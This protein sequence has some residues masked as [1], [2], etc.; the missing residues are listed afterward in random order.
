MAK[1]KIA[2][3]FTDWGMNDYRKNNNLYGGIG[4]YRIVKPAEA[5][6]EWYDIDVIGANFRFWGN[7]EQAFTRLCKDY[8]LIYSKHID[9]GKAGSNILALANHFNKK[10]IVD[11][12]DNYLAIREDNPAYKDY[13]PLKGG[14]YFLGAFM[15][16][17]N[18][19]TTSTQPL[20][21]AYSHLNPNIDVLPNCNDI[22]DWKT[23]PNKR[24]D[25]KIRIG[26]QGS[27]T[28]ND[29]LELIIPSVARILT[30]YPNVIF[31][32]C[33]AIPKE[34]IKYI[35]KRFNSYSYKNL[36]KQLG[37]YGGTQAWLGYPELLADFGWDIGLA[38]LINE[39]FNQ[40]KSHI[41]F[42]EYAMVGVPTIASPVYPYKEPIQGVPVIEHG[43][44][45]LF[46]NCHEEWSFYLEE[47]IMKEDYRKQIAKNAYEHIRDNWQ[48]SQH[49]DKWRAV[50]DKYL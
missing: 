43:K 18:G 10:V 45:G 5:L 22:N 35:V 46:A 28:H 42:M 25:G 36:E 40:G 6:K 30:K 3:L 24:N 8:D 16:L 21:E 32:I 26:Y 39:V 13:A 12:D 14:R 1:P 2:F 48:W 11:L 41:K 33:G 4:Y 47:L 7:E 49:T 20:K 19:L 34:R 44:T 31:Q 23:P 9:T 17:S 15:S 37:F 50:I 27:V 38:P 29:D